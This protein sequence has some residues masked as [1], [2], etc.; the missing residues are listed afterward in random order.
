MHE[1][2]YNTEKIKEVFKTYGYEYI[3]GEALNQ[4]SK[5]TISDGDGYLYHVSISPLINKNKNSKK[6]CTF[7]QGNP[8]TIE[9]IHRFIY[10]NKCNSVLISDSYNNNTDK[11]I[12]KCNLCGCEYKRA[13]GKFRLS[14]YMCNKCSA[15]L[16]TNKL[17]SGEVEDRLFKKGWKLCD[18]EVYSGNSKYINVVNK[19]GYMAYTTLTNIE[20]SNTSIE[21]F[22]RRNP[23]TI[24][25]IRLYLK[26]NKTNL[27]LLSDK[28]VSNTSNLS[29]KCGCGNEFKKSLSTLFSNR[30]YGCK[31]CLLLYRANKYRTDISDIYDICKNNNYTLLNFKYNNQKTKLKV[32]D[33][34]GYLYYIPISTITDADRPQKFT[35]LNIYRMHNLYN[36]IKLNNIKCKPIFTNYY[37]QRNEKLKFICECGNIFETTVEKFIY[38]NKHRCKKCAISISNLE[39]QTMD[40]LNKKNIEYISQY[41]YN[42]LLGVNNRNLR[43]DIY[44]PNTNTLIEVNGSQHYMAFSYFGGNEKFKIQL[45]HDK[46]KREY[47]KNNNIRLIEIPYWEFK[48]NEYV[49][50]L[51]YAI[52]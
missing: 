40:Y 21:L 13:W 35:K 12:W 33:S 23:H 30:F 14:S 6:Y 18:G 39:K 45:E 31:D 7:G 28:Y 25:N 48:T 17:S 42:N 46:R 26:L 1:R 11:L 8:Y 43:Y 19:D 9:N 36:Y 10:L 27:E 5:V 49:K 15:K 47:A 44:I 4:N 52:E 50:Y 2:K 20:A 37:S 24:Y 22:D 32:I 41:T 3:F 16:N 38:S 34:Y 51:D 29:F